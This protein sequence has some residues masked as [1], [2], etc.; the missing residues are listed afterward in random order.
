MTVKDMISSVSIEA[1]ITHRNFLVQT[2]T[3][4]KKQISLDVGD[5]V[6]GE[7]WY[8]GACWELAERVSE[9]ELVV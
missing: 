5:V 2:C 3:L 8:H 7:K 4:C 1:G 9:P 6:F